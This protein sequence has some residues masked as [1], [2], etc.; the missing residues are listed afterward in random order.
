MLCIVVSDAYPFL[1]SEFSQKAFYEPHISLIITILK[2]PNL[3]KFMLCSVVDSAIQS[4]KCHYIYSATSK[5]SFSHFILARVG[6]LFT[7]N[8][9]SIP[10]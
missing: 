10:R 2:L 1:C 5:P 6:F 7:V 4:A 8:L 3:G 9:K